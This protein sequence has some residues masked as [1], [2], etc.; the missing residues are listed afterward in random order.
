MP[1]QPVV[2]EFKPQRALLSV[3][4][5]RGLVELAQAL[6]QQG[7]EL[8]ATGNTAVVLKTQGLPVTDVSDHT[9]FPEL[10]DG[11]VKT[12]H[13]TIHAGLL[14]RGAQDKD[15]LKQHGIKPIDLLIVNLYPFE[16]TISKPNCDFNEAIEQID[17]GG[18]TMIRAAAK[19]HAHTFV[20]V[21]PDDYPELIQCL[22]TKKTPAN[23]GLTLAKKAFAHTAAYD[24]AITNYL[25]STDKQRFP[26]VFTCQFHKISDLRYGENPHQAAAFYA[27]KD[28]V[29]GSLGSAQILQ[30]KQLSYNN[31]LDADAALDC[32]KSYPIEKAICVIVKH[33]NPCGIAQADTALQAYLRAFQSDPISAYG[34]IIAFNQTLQADTAQAILEKQFVEVIIAPGISDEAKQILQ[35]KEQIRV[36]ITGVWPQNS[37]N[38]INIKKT[39]GGLLVQTHDALALPG[40]ELH[41]VTA[42]KPTQQQMDD[43]TFAWLAA[44]HVKSNAIV[45]A[46]E[47]AT[48][49]I[50]GGQTSRVMSARIGLW[51]AEQMGFKTQDAVMASDAFIPFAD[52]IELAAQAG[53]TAIIQPGGSIRDQQMIA[54]AEEHNITMVFT[55]MRHFKH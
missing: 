10:L 25:T 19:N 52:T 35:H 22:Q 26:D 4:D 34:G 20:V 8:I 2:S 11:R 13:P 45:F 12:L 23:W 46:R 14:A 55:G 39:D 18:P 48:I 5:K 36:L 47:G 16:Q 49:G 44:K 7:V 28:A 17:I 29:P 54:C 41:T 53:I 6:H 30:G 24:A 9:G 40:C 37:S 38:K 1:Q 43:L 33:A 42:T 15:V 32:V 27:D 51:Q 21:T 50:G 31:L 3:S